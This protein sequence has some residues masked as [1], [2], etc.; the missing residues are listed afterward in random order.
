MI[1]DLGKKI[2]IARIYREMI[3]FKVAKASKIQE[4]KL[5]KIENGHIYPTI[6][7]LDSIST[8]LNVPLEFWLMPKE[9]IPE[10]LP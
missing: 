1:E 6:K 10:S 2:R 9:R 7:E 4:S 8:A 3:Q 5:S